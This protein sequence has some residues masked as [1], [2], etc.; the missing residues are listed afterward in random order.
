[1]ELWSRARQLW[2]EV[3]HPRH[4]AR[5]VTTGR[6]PRLEMAIKAAL[7]ALIAWQVALWLP[8]APAEEYPYYAPLGAVVASYTSVRTSFTESVSSVLAILTGAALALTASEVVPAD[9]VLVPLVVGVGVLLAGLPFFGGQSSWVPIAALFVLVI[10]DEDPFT[11]VRAYAGLTLLGAALAVAI[12]TLLPTVPLAQ[13]GRAL[14]RLAA[15]LADQ[16]DDLADG[17][18]SDEPPS[19]AQWRER[20]LAIDP[21]L[22]SVR[23]SGSD[24]RQSLKVNARARRE[25]GTIERQRGE[26]IVLDSVATR[27]ADLTAMLIDVHVAGRTYAEVEEKLREPIARALCA[28]ADAVRPLG[29]EAAPR[30]PEVGVLRQ[31]VRDLS[32]EVAAEQMPDNLSREMAGA[33]VTAVRRLLGALASGLEDE[34]ERRSEDEEAVRPST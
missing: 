22:A 33:V 9:V 18:R 7:A 23:S 30:A 10:G 1:M 14:S 31:E 15:T 26:A 27:T 4:L 13:S 16:L 17:L 8:F 34:H 25:R 21:V 11:Y 2:A 28:A 20:S 24:V 5:L 6:W 29:E 19:A 12:T 32:Q 3:G